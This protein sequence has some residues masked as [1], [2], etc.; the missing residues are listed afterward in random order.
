MEYLKL[1]IVE[2]DD[3]AVKMY[4][5]VAK[6]YGADMQIEF[7][8]FQVRNLSESTEI[9]NKEI[10]DGICVDL[11]LSTDGAPESFQGNEII[12]RITSSSR[13][14]VIVLSAN[15]MN[16]SDEAK[17]KVF[18]TYDRTT[19]FKIV[20]E[21][22][23]LINKSGLTEIMNNTGIIEKYLNK[24][25]WEVIAQRIN[26]WTQYAKKSDKTKDALLR[27]ILNH[28]IEAID[29][30]A[31]CYLPDEVYLNIVSSSDLKPGQI[32]TDK[33]TSENYIILSPACDL[34]NHEKDGP[35]SDYIQ[36]CKIDCI[37]SAKLESICADK[38]LVLPDQKAADFDEKRIRRKNAKAVIEDAPHNNLLFLH[39]LPQ[40]DLFPGGIIN[41]R[42]IISEKRSQFIDRFTLPKI[43]ISST[44]LKDI[45]ARFS[46][47]YAR[48]GQPVY[49]FCGK[50][51][52]EL[53][54]K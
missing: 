47:Y 3:A 17:K 50:K 21:M 19:D 52:L 12:T 22:F 40:S 11:K 41:F 10:F 43:Q 13:W 27:L 7:H 34:Y 24:I 33:K 14:P 18:Q 8:L 2:D 26:T 48:Q 39:Y 54:R 36:A 4:R 5:E 46:S 9:M 44:F 6:E 42:E 51:G 29:N 25:Y 1:L 32:I 49:D 38:D 45:I 16:I 15:Y 53:L 31:D 28:L 37:G 20:L 35:K 30:T 23:Y